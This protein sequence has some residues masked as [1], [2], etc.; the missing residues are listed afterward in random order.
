MHNWHIEIRDRKTL[1]WPNSISKLVQKGIEKRQSQR[2]H[3]GWTH[4]QLRGKLFPRTNN[5]SWTHCTLKMNLQVN[6]YL[7]GYNRGQVSQVP[8]GSLAL[9]CEGLR[10]CLKSHYYSPLYM[11]SYTQKSLS[12]QI[13]Q[14]QISS[15]I[16]Q[17]ICR[18]IVAFP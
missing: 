14:N 9:I 11:R 13:N 18:D 1:A 2:T 15:R 3:V 8:P 16:R 5:W 6:W 17:Y 10:C 4:S 12:F 7:L